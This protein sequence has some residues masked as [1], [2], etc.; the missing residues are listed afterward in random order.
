MQFAKQIK[1][2]VPDVWP[3]GFPALAQEGTV[4]RFYSYLFMTGATVLN[5][6]NTKAAFNSEGGQKALQFLQDLVKNGYTPT[7]VLGQDPDQ[8]YEALAAGKYGMMLAY[9]GDGFNNV[10]SAPEWADATP[11]QRAD[12]TKKW[13]DLI[14]SELPPICDTCEPASAAGGWMLS[15]GAESPNKDLAWEYI[16]DV[17]DAQNILPFEA[18]YARVPVRLSGLDHPEAFA[19]DPYFSVTASAV[20]IAKFPPFVP[21]YTQVIEQIWT[22]IQRAVQGEDVKTVLDDAAAATDAI[23][24]PAE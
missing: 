19:D 1:E 16:M 15:I 22:A 5:E 20:P 24:A 2:N 9:T 8:I 14:G 4:D 6:D 13:S 21:K 11:E 17:T 7:D 23:L 3:V 18:Q 12:M 10:S